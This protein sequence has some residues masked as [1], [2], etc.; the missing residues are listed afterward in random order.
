MSTN[1]VSFEKRGWLYKF[2]VPIFIIAGLIISY[3][4]YIL[5]SLGSYLITEDP[6]ERADAIVVLAGSVPDRVLEA[7]DIFKQ[8]YAPFIILTKEEKSTGYDRLLNLGLRIPEGHDLNKMIAVKLGVPSTSIFIIDE[9][10]DNTYSEMEVIY[11]FLKKRNLKSIILVTSKSHTT[12]ATKIFSLVNDETK[13]KIITRPSKYDTF[14]PKKW[15]KVRRDWKQTI[16][17]YQKLA[18]Y[19]LHVVVSPLVNEGHL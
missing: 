10:S 19:Y 6:L 2:V 12:R 5:I 16:Y 7:V 18:H 8:G 15:W 3:H 9:R 17:E 14:E 4:N 13:I 1:K 11:D